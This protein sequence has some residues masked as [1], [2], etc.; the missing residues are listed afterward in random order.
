MVTD[1]IETTSSSGDEE[2]DDLYCLKPPSWKQKRTSV[3]V[4]DIQSPGKIRCL[5]VTMCQTYGT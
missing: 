3:K 4:I 1:D 2:L 5:Y